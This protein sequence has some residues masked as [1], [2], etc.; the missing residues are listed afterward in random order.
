MYGDNGVFT[1]KHIDYGENKPKGR[2][3]WVTVYTTIAYQRWM[4]KLQWPA[5]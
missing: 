5:L 1:L 4:A 3:W 2:W